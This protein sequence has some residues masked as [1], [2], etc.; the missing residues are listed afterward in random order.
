MDLDQTSGFSAAELVTLDAAIATMQQ[1]MNE[2]CFR[3]G[4]ESSSMTETQGMDPDQVYLTIMGGGTFW[5]EANGVADLLID[6]YD[7]PL[8]RTI[9]YVETDDKWVYVNKKYF[10][11]PAYVGSLL[12]H[13]YSHQEGFTHYEVLETSVPYTINRVFDTCASPVDRSNDLPLNL[14]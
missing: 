1:V 13:E 6:L 7:D 12:A 11:T 10:G 14:D 8:S 5:K 9:G 3:D 4:I 2:S